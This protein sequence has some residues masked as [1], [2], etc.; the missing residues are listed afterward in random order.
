MESTR[1]GIR[2]VPIRVGSVSKKVVF[3]MRFVP[4]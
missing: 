2:A 3:G 4:Q 1:S